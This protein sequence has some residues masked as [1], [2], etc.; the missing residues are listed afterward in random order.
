MLL[1][2]VGQSNSGL[3]GQFRPVAAGDVGNG[4]ERLPNIR[5]AVVELRWDLWPSVGDGLGV[6]E[7]EPGALTLERCGPAALSV[8]S[9]RMV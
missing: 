1:G 4:Q 7:D 8:D 6:I 2:R 9:C 3:A 5:G